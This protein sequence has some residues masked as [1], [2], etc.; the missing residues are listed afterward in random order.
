M[1]CG[2]GL[3]KRPATAHV[4]IGKYYADSGT[5]T[6]AIHGS[7]IRKMQELVGLN[8]QC[9]AH[10]WLPYAMYYLPLEEISSPVS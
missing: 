9:N 3:P 5:P 6:L 10:A 4:T 8:T 7:L 1:V 2:S